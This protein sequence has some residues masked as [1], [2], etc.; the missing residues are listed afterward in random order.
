MT[1]R[2]LPLVALLLLAPAILIAQFPPERP[3]PTPAIPTGPRE[4]RPPGPGQFP[5][6]DPCQD[7][8]NQPVVTL[9]LTPAEIYQGDS[10][11]ATWEVRDRRPGIQW[12]YP[13][14]IETPAPPQPRFP[15]PA[16][17]VGSH[18]FTTPTVSGRVTLRTR[19]GEHSVDWVR[20]HD[21]VLRILQ[22]ETG[23]GG[24]TVRIRGSWFGERQGSSRVE[25]IAGGQTRTMAVTSWGDA[26]I[27]ATVPNGMPTGQATIRVVKGGRRET[28]TI[29]FRVN[30]R[31]T[32][33]TALAR[34]AADV[35]GLS[36]TQILLTDGPNASR[37]TLGGGLSA[38]A[39]TVPRF[40]KDV[41]AS[42]NILEAALVPVPGLPIPLKVRFR[43][44]DIRSNN[45]DVS[46]ANGQIVVSVGFESRGTEIIGEART[47]FFAL[48]GCVDPEW[49]DGHCPD[50][51]V[52]NARVTFRLTPGV[53]GGALTFPSATDSFEASIQIGSNFANWLLPS[54]RD[55]ADQVKREIGGG[56]HNALNT[57]A[58]RNAA[59]T[60]VMAQLRNL[61]V[62]EI[63]GVTPSGNQ[64]VV[65]YE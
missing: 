4:P 41:P 13:V 44:N 25:I 57:A 29:I 50:I 21:A 52:N 36:A 37:V 8:S 14:H 20:I 17:R 53:S 28:G 40:Q 59:A 42:A 9:S 32:I 5:L 1:N 33:D 16:P 30:R 6:P 7:F 27:E 3:G 64:I 24:S 26:L 2:A 49:R 47:C 35:A 22:P 11:T 62:R 45:V 48:L 31:V 10:I 18:T 65:E 15:D 55:W 23:S 38:F 63:V 12:G 58:V 46:V 56:I 54:L 43:A 34:L 51:Q 60:A 19:C 39:F 61:G